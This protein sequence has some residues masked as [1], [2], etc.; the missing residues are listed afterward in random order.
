[1]LKNYNCYAIAIHLPSY[2]HYVTYS[3]MFNFVFTDFGR[4]L[5][6][7][8]FLWDMVRRKKSQIRQKKSTVFNAISSCQV[9]AAQT[10]DM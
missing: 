9:Y 5:R 8:S 6:Q 1:M 2:R 3:L 4:R 10:L 7:R